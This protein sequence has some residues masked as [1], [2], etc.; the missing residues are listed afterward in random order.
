MSTYPSDETRA[1]ALDL[2]AADRAR[3][4]RLLQGAL[5]HDLKA[6]LNTAT[7][8]LDLLG[9][10]L[11][12][13]TPSE[14]ARWRQVENVEEIRREL[15]R[16]V[17][18]LPGLLSLPEPTAGQRETIDLVERLPWMLRLLR[19]QALLRGVRIRTELPESP[20]PVISIDSGVEHVF[21][22][23]A[24]NALEAMANGGTLFVSARRTKGEV[25]WVVEDDGPGLPIEWGDRVFERHVSTKEGRSGLGL[26]IARE[27]VLEHGG[28]IHLG[29]GE[30]SGTRAEIRWPAAKPI[31]AILTQESDECRTP[32]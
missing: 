30:F 23:V 10:S 21:L 12:Q 9:R 4:R 16:L 20:L 28:T 26:A 29:P 3:L 32:S 11:S 5:I 22:G 17:E 31:P 25:Q 8:L 24:V 18:A 15:R 7:L 2:R 13:G 19:Q 1:L 14:E 6:P 27:I